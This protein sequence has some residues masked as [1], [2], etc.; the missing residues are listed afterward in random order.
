MRIRCPNCSWTG[1]PDGLLK[2]PSPFDPE[3]LLTAC[4]NCKTVEDTDHLCD[5]EGCRELSGMGVPMKDGSY[6]WR[7]HNHRPAEEERK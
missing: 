2:A 4:P 6:T 1:T 7:C 5:I 3:D